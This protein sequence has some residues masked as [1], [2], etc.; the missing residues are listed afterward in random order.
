MEAKAELI[1]CILAP[2]GKKEELE[3]NI[4]SNLETKGI[5]SL[6]KGLVVPKGKPN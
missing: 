1:N 2:C 3:E 4:L 6:I 5:K